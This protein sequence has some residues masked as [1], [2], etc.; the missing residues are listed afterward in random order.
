[1]LFT[2]NGAWERGFITIQQ[3]IATNNWNL[4]RNLH[5]PGL[6]IVDNAVFDLCYVESALVF[7]ALFS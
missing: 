1:M 3:Q 7:G 4:Y 2:F 5:T 6:F